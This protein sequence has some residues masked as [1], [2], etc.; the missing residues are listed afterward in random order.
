MELEP[1]LFE[2]SSPSPDISEAFDA[3]QFLDRFRQEANEQKIR[4][5]SPIKA[6]HKDFED[7]YTEEARDLVEHQSEQ[8][9]RLGGNVIENPEKNKQYYEENYVKAVRFVGKNSLRMAENGAGY[10]AENF[11]NDERRELILK[12]LAKDF[13]RNNY[14]LSEKVDA[15]N[16]VKPTT[17][18]SSKPHIL[19]PKD[20]QEIS[21]EY[22]SLGSSSIRKVLIGRDYNV[23]DFLTMTKNEARKIRRTKT[24]AE[25]PTSVINIALI[26]YTSNPRAY[27]D[28]VLS[29]TKQLMGLS[30]A[31]TKS[32]AI[33]IARTSGKELTKTGEEYE[34][35]FNE[36]SNLPKYKDFG[37]S[38]VKKGLR[39]NLEDPVSAMDEIV[40]TYEQLSNDPELSSTPHYLIK[41]FSINY[42]SEEKTKSALL[43]GQQ[44]YEKLVNNKRFVDFFDFRTLRNVAYNNRFSTNNF[45][46]NVLRR[47]KSMR[48]NEEFEIIDNNI[49]KSVLIRSPRVA[50][51]KLTEIVSSYNQFKNDPRYMH[52][53]DAYIKDVAQSQT[54][55]P[56][57]YLNKYLKSH[58]TYIAE[59]GL[60]KKFSAYT[61]KNEFDRT[62]KWAKRN[63]TKS[64]SLFDELADEVDLTN[65]GP[66]FLGYACLYRPNQIEVF[67]DEAR[68][69]IYEMLDDP[70]YTGFEVNYIKNIV[71]ESF[72]NANS[73][74]LIENNPEDIFDKL[75]ADE[76]FAMF[77]LATIKSAVNT[78]GPGNAERIL[79]HLANK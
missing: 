38:I 60:D 58:N 5:G 63:L 14:L 37:A 45:L 40:S 65:L 30:K 62:N 46:N 19:G 18:K 41:R 6:S 69:K 51:E 43:R 77:P 73:E 27:L 17:W 48:T 8:L 75:Y 7:L 52:L 3:S 13:R 36:L 78:Y 25:L 56:E 9:V 15:D 49:I 21:S 79:L 20:M 1:L 33:N 47:Y 11:R 70:K 23:K 28:T 50:Y 22:S 42:V 31:I 35:K 34:T 61:I 59:N 29:R 57:V 4:A 26:D 54:K 2:S 72:M 32:T 71:L 44:N 24:Y 64:S 53:P 76:R 12:Q 74:K 67:L 16:P 10:F 39:N 68:S 55:K 66:H